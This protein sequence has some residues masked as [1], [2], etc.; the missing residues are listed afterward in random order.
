[1]GHLTTDIYLPSL[2]AIAKYFNVS[3]STVQLTVSFYL[4]SMSFSP[5]LFGPLSDA[6]GRKKVIIFGLILCTF[7]TMCCS[8]A[9]NV[10]FLMVGRTLQGI[11]VGAIIVSA[12]AMV[13]D[14]YSGQELAKRIT[15]VT[16]LMPLIL[17]I[18]P[19]IGG[20]I[21]EYFQWRVVFWVLIIYLSILLIVIPKIT[22]TVK[23]KIKMN[24]SLRNPFA[25][26]ACYKELIT[27]TPFMLYGMCSVVPISGMFAYLTISPFL[28][29]NILGLSPSAYGRLSLY[30][31]FGILVSGYINTT[32]IKRWPLDTLLFVGS[33]IVISAGILLWYFIHI[34]LKSVLFTIL[35]VLL[36]YFCNTIGIGNA[37][38]KAL[39]YLEGSFGTARA[40][41]ATCQFLAGA[42]GSFV[43][44][45][46]PIKDGLYLS[47]CFI[48]NGTLMIICVLKAQK[49]AKQHKVTS[50]LRYANEQ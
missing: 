11:A 21:Q 26:I 43:F 29:Q 19:T 4:I 18:A 30:I 27:N 6:W 1:L 14:L 10:Y 3:T 13:P 36:F 35:P 17:A 32:L 2:P 28:F 24:V 16:M 25:F 40:L 39:T 12:R 31:G 44:S 8:F 9:P 45:I 42:L 50:I 38:S 23:T 46:L 22:E 37:T 49:T 47:I 20:Y 48:I 34:E 15:Q 33:G 7:A 41:L 5:L